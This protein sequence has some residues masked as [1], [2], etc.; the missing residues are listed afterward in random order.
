MDTEQAQASGKE[1]LGTG[2]SLMATTYHSDIK[3]HQRGD[4]RF[5]I[6]TS[7]HYS[8]GDSRARQGFR[9]EVIALKVAN[10]HVS[11]HIVTPRL[12]LQR[13]TN[14]YSSLFRTM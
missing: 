7:R 1:S 8:E 9:N 2:Q 5:V 11:R 14:A 4:E 12:F 10:E 6:K 3:L 13:E